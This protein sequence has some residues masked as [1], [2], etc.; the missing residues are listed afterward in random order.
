MKLI[1]IIIIII[2]KIKNNNNKSYFISWTTL[3]IVFM[4]FLRPSVLVS[5]SLS[6]PWEFLWNFTLSQ[7]LGLQ[8]FCSA[9]N[10]CFIHSSPSLRSFSQC[11]IA[12]TTDAVQSAN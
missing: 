2:I 8:F 1:I 4:S 11:D 3:R 7:Q 10:V 5:R 12:L 9:A 6:T